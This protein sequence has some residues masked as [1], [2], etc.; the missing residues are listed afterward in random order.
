MKK[1]LLALAV[2]AVAF[3]TSAASAAQVYDKDGTTL[4]VGGQV[5]FMAASAGNGY[6]GYGD[7]KTAKDS[8]TRDRARLT[9]AGR[10]QITNGIS[11]YAYNEWQVDH[12]GDSNESQSVKARQQYLGVDF[13]VFGKVQAGRYKDPFVYAS[14]V[15]DDG[16][17][18]VG[19]YG[20]QDERNSGHLSY[21]W[22]GW[23]VDAGISYQFAEDNYKTD[24]V[25][26]FFNTDK[27]KFNVDSGF[28][29]YAGYTSP[30]V[31][32][33]PIGVRAAYLYLKGQDIG[34]SY[35]YVGQSNGNGG[36]FTTGALPID[37]IKTIDGSLFW[38]TNGKGFYIATNYN[39]SKMTMQDE[40]T[41]FKVKA[42]E[43]VITYGFDCGV[44]L[45][46]SYH[47]I[48]SEVDSAGVSSKYVKVKADQGSDVDVDTK[49]VQLIADYNVTPNFKVWVEGL[50]DAGSD[51]GYAYFNTSDQKDSNNSVMFG[52]RY[53]F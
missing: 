16:L 4:S 36:T 50:I 8:T 31:W 48:K 41:E 23:G 20:G 22:S 42:W 7:G 19:I 40:D 5:E 37:D 49:Y 45:G 47:W 38:G 24:I 18:E 29:V 1:S 13:C 35:D 32:F 53:T 44:R 17:D 3:A 27:Y 34:E 46:V 43:S 25:A 2:A 9:M 12:A 33:G 15:V 39:W 52:A 26:Q 30:S 11:A 51:D 6:F 28:S 10:T 14:K 21:M